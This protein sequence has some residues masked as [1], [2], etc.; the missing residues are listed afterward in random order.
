MRTILAILPLLFCLNNS[1][2]LYASDEIELGFEAGQLGDAPDRWAV[3][4]AGW[5]AELTKERSP[6]GSRCLKLHLP[7]ATNA[8]FGNVMTTRPAGDWTGRKVTLTATILVLGNGRGQMWL[9]VDRKTG[10]MGAFDNMNDRPIVAGG[11]RDAKIEA[12][13]DSDAA[14]VNIGFM[15]IGG[16]TLFIDDLQ[17]SLSDD[18]R[19]KQAPSPPQALTERGLANVVAAAKLVSYLRFFHPSDQAVGVA[20]W[21]HVAV[22]VIERCEPAGDAA[23]LAQRLTAAIAGIAPTVQVWAGDVTKAPPMEPMPKAAR[24]LRAWRH[25]GA[26]NIQSA[27]QTPIYRSSVEMTSISSDGHG[28]N[29]EFAVKDLG[30]GVSC[31]VPISVYADDE[32]TLPHAAT[33][34]AL[35]D[36]SQLP[37]LTVRNRATRLAGV[38][39][40][41]GVFQHFYPYFD[42]V[43][44][45]WEAALPAAL[46]KAA[47]DTDERAYLNTLRESVAK[48]HDGHGN[49][50]CSAAQ[51]MTTLPLALAWAGDDLVVVGKQ[52]SVPASVTIGD[53]LV[54]IDERPIAECYAE[55]SKRISA[56]TEGW[57]R[58]SAA[59]LIVA[60]LPTTDPVKLGLR[61]PDGTT[62]TVQV[63]RSTQFTR[64]TATSKRPDNGAELADG[65]V[66]FDLNGAKVESLMALMPTLAAAKAIIFDMRGYPDSAATEL[67]QH[68]IDEP[69]Q[70]A[71]WR[72]PIVRRPDRENIE[73]SE[74]GR[75][76]LLPKEPRLTAKVAF[77]T[78]GRA[79]SYAESIMGIV[80][81]YKLGEIVGATTPAPTAT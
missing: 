10:G 16:A 62:T 58:W 15:A 48:L 1:T 31:R 68:L 76:N 51:Q 5:T 17:V 67:T 47:E 73:W 64:N 57:R 33:P 11:W 35:T 27:I 14:L 37:Q 12:E 53:A 66:Y 18:V 4:T 8:P 52:D 55:V 78:D 28:P 36:A 54:A 40:A 30:G 21:D 42:V 41:W 45:D 32:G 65:V 38:A 59:R 46:T 29:R 56:A 63:D 13:I 3:P 80:E 39:L 9:R 50:C 34:A 74:S 26:G 20:S 79:V 25:S 49:V 69:A 81:N 19:A 71:R 70:S 7:G 75:W 43:E 61:K 60:D 23:D 24:N 77:L 2:P 44:T 6:V 72:I 22:D